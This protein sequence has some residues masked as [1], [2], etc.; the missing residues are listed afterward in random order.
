[1][2]IVKQ[3]M[4]ELKLSELVIST[5]KYT[6]GIPKDGTYSLTILFGMGV[7]K[8][9][10]QKKVAVSYGF[11]F[12]SDRDEKYIPRIARRIA[13]GR[14]A[15]NPGIFAANVEEINKHGISGV[16]P[17]L[18]AM[19]L[20]KK[21]ETAVYRKVFLP[22]SKSKKMLK[23]MLEAYIESYFRGGNRMKKK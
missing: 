9:D 17:V 23:A 16:V 18:I 4:K 6:N 19:D 22:N 7:Y 21:L 8:A 1:M 3:K 2:N 15:E 12:K 14:I 10:P 20:M 11:A 13:L 5:E